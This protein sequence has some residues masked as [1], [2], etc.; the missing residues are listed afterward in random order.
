MA[1]STSRGGPTA[2]AVLRRALMA[3]ALLMAAA[4]PTV[5]PAGVFNPE[6]F[7]LGNGMRVVVIPNHRAPVVSHMVW[8][9][10]G[11]ADEQPGKSGVAH[12]LEHLMF[13]GT[14]KMPGRRFSE[15]VARNGGQENAF[16]SA[17]YTGYYQNVAKDRLGLVMGLEADRMVNL[18]LAES[19]VRIE[20][21]V[22]LEERRSRVDNEPTARLR[23]QMHAAL[24]MNHPYGTPIIGWEHEIRALTR[25]DAMDWYR[26]YYAPNNAI[27]VVAGDVTADEVRPLAEAHYGAIPARELAPRLRP[28]EPPHHA[29]RQV[30]LQSPRVRQPLWMRSYLAPSYRSGETQHAYAL[31]VLA[32]ILGGNATSRLYR[33][34]VVDRALA[35]S[36]GAHYNP[37]NLDLAEFSVSLSPRPGGPARASLAELA[38]AYEGLIADLLEN[39]VSED[40]V[41]RAKLRMRAQAIYARDGLRTGARVLGRALAIGRTVEDVESWPERIAAVTVDQVN[42]AARAVFVDRRSVTGLLLPK[43][44]S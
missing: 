8:Y 21:D 2:G 43:P 17:D 27:L 34:L 36:A 24:Y 33:G 5:A 35:A 31:E 10:V 4:A 26:R 23:E 15:T 30:T 7:T 16:T 20:R 12:F 1:S 38:A 9:K 25:A 3:A 13:K 22:I 39:G 41:A 6:T 11:A 42:R 29:P 19:D 32:Q 40:E 18:V 37:G 44:A 28:A 14:D